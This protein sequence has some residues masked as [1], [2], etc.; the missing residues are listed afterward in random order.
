VRRLPCSVAISLAVLAGTAGPALGQGKPAP[1]PA[2]IEEARLHM[3]AGHDFYEDPR[4]HRCE[5]ALVEFRKAYEL[6]GSLNARKGMAVCNLLLERDG[7][8]IDDY[9]AF[10]AGKG[11]SLDPK[12]KAEVE[13]D[14]NALKQAVA[15]VTVRVDADGVRIV[16]VRTP[17]SGPSVRNG[18]TLPRGETR[19]GLHPGDHV[20]TASLEGRPDQVW[21]VTITNG[22][23]IAHAF[24]FGT[25]P[26]PAATV[27]ETPP[28]EPPEPP[29]GTTR[30]VP[31]YVWISGGATLALVVPWVA[32]AVRAKSKN[33]DYEALN[34]KAP[35]AELQALRSDVKNA[36][37]V[38]DVFLGL[39]AAGV[40]TT[41]VLFLT[42]PSK[43]AQA[44]RGRSW[45]VAPVLGASSGGVVMEGWF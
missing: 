8:A 29:Q 39:T 41:V 23:S 18:Y 40:A 32:L 22:A 10:L 28:P 19:L 45:T 1:D 21:K 12:E 34:G 30:P 13:A 9:T 7:D 6:S 24:T 3:K 14:L 44:S 38:A 20:L 4:G 36:N 37:L 15:H 16:D 2:K 11:A 33:D 25:G 35:A 5:E 42:R 31:P 17:A 26:A 27:A 43:P